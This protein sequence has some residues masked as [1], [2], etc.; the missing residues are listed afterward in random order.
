MNWLIYWWNILFPEKKINPYIEKPKV[1]EELNTEEIPP[2]TEGEV[3]AKDGIL[4]QINE[5]APEEESSK[6][7]IT[8][9][10]DLNLSGNTSSLH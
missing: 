10:T 2:A 3:P 6:Q 5:E 1:E 4:E 7:S 8:A 9:T